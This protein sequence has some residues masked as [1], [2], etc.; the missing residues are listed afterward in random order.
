MRR[1]FTLI[2]I[3]I[4]MTITAV[5]SLLLH[6]ALITSVRAVKTVDKAF[7]TPRQALILSRMLQ[8]ELQGILHPS[9]LEPPAPEEGK[10]PPPRPKEKMEFGLVGKEKEI[11]FTT[12]LP[13]TDE[14]MEKFGD[15]MEIGYEYDL[16]RGRLLKRIDPFP[17]EDVERGGEQ[18][19]LPMRVSDVEFE[20]FD[21]GWRDKW[22]S[23]KSNTLPRA[24]RLTLKIRIEEEEAEDLSSD[25]EEALEFDHQIL[26][27]LVNSSENKSRF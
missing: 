7:K 4:V 24:I 13:M 27:L 3:L 11:H 25:E 9:Y 20:F 1:G 14:Q 2:E 21:T 18:I 19:E 26:V 10:E 22:D 17:D 15:V 16:K 8:R 5:A 6:N 12:L 23:T